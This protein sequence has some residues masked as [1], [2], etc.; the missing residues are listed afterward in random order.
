MRCVSPLSF[1]RDPLLIL[2]AAS[3]PDSVKRI[4]RDEPLIKKILCFP[5]ALWMLVIAR[6]L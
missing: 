1:L 6:G 5:T 3:G 2:H 4:L